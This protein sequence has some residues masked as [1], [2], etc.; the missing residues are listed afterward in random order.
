[1]HFA[2]TVDTGAEHACVSFA[3]SLP[4]LVAAPRRNV[5]NVSVSPG[6]LGLSSRDALQAYSYQRRDD[7]PLGLR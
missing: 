6:W 7:R 5:S 2:T 3:F 1:M 4:Y